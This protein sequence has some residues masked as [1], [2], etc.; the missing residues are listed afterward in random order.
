MVIVGFVE[1][2]AVSRGLAAKH[3]YQVSPNRELVAFGCANI[4]GS[5]FQTYPC[6]A[7]IPRTSIQDSAG[8]R[9]CLC[10]FI[11]SCLLLLTILFL[12]PL[13]YFLPHVT[14]AAIIFVAAFGL[15]EVHEAIF[16]WKTKSWKELFQFAIAFFSTFLLQVEL[17]ILIS[18]GMCIFLVLKHSSTPHVYSVLGRMPGSGFFKDVAKNP[19]AEPIEGII[20]IRIDETL[21]FANMGEF[22]LLL[23]DLEK[24]T[25]KKIEEGSSTARIQ[26]I[27]INCSNIP[28]MDAS[29]LLTLLEMVET[30]NHRGVR[31]VFIQI[32]EAIHRMFELGGLLKLIGEES[33]F[34]SNHGAIRYLEVNVIKK[35]PQADNFEVT[36]KRGTPEL[37]E[38]PR[39][40][41][42]DQVTTGDDDVRSV[43]SYEQGEDLSPRGQP[44]QPRFNS[45]YN[46]TPR[47]EEDEFYEITP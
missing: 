36:S 22:K 4:V 3:N 8:S 34:E 45:N 17:G 38:T 47:K 9:T 18:V 43:D 33:I 25:T 2:T 30:Y 16:L 26:A 37:T 46:L 11:T 41:Q 19:D 35:V 24:L 31:V 42:L 10:G 13:F 28:N 20:L 32:N 27:A 23:D 12:T 1:A 6:F 39:L 44:S 15:I 29:A 21:M 40:P 14:M 7:S 5:F